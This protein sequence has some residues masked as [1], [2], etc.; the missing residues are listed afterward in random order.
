M[1]EE[2]LKN[3]IKIIEIAVDALA[4]NRDDEGKGNKST[5]K[6]AKIIMNELEII[7]K[8]SE[9]TESGKV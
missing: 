3:R 1:T 6:F 5:A 9:K 4:S 8:D 2:E 7:I